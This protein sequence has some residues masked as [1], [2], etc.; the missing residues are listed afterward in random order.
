MLHATRRGRQTC[1]NHQA[2]TG[3][4]KK[5]KQKEKEKHPLGSVLRKCLSQKYEE[6][7]SI[8]CLRNFLKFNQFTPYTIEH[9]AGTSGKTDS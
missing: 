2:Q 6:C 5:K 1:N 9:I 7:V 4:E 3:S 8:Q